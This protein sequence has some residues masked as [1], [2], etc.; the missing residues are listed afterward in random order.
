MGRKDLRARF[1]RRRPDPNAFLHACRAHGAHRRVASTAR[2]PGWWF[3]R[4][5]CGV[6][7]AVAAFAWAPLM[8]RTGVQGPGRSRCLLHRPG[9][10]AD[11]VRRV[12]ARALQLELARAAGHPD[13]AV[14]GVRAVL[15]I[16]LAIFALV[17]PFW[18]LFDQKASTWVFQAGGDDQTRLVRAR[19]RC[20]RINP[21]AGDAAHPVQQ[22]GAVPGPASPFGIGRPSGDA[23]A[24]PLGIAL[25]RRLAWI[26]A[27]ASCSWRCSMAATPVSITWQ[28][29]PYV[30]LTAWARYWVSATGLEFAYSQAPASMKGAIMSF[31]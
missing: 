2:G 3:D 22:P 5:R 6:V 15:G 27:G 21:A 1:R 31:W 18:S 11:R 10:P 14:D 26:V 28:I 29:L 23:G 9:V 25:L 30:L 12:S 24:S 13:E 7:L 4:D 8:G 20:R 19:L 16:L 17:T